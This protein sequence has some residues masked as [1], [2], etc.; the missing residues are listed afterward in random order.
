MARSIPAD[1]V[2]TGRQVSDSGHWFPAAAL[3]LRS[4]RSQFPRN[5][6]TRRFSPWAVLWQALCLEF[7]RDS[8]SPNTGGVVISYGDVEVD[9]KTEIFEIRPDVPQSEL[10]RTNCDYVAQT[11]GASWVRRFW[12]SCGL[13]RLLLRTLPLPLARRISSLPLRPLPK[14]SSD[15]LCLYSR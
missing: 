8:R 15:C 2:T 3:K 9:E 12:F 14:R 4:H 13:H 6:Y 11:N 7:D 10:R 1:A 5:Q